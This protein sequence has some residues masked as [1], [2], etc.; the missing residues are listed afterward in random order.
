MKPRHFLLSLLALFACITTKAT[1]GGT[2][3]VSIGDNNTQMTLKILSEASKTV[4]VTSISDNNVTAATIASTYT[5][6]GTEYTVVSIGNFAFKDKDNLIELNLPNTIT[7]I[8]LRAFMGCTALGSLDHTFTIP[9]NVTTIESEAFSGCGYFAGPIPTSVTSIGSGAFTSTG[10]L[11]NQPDGIVYINNMVYTYKGTMPA[12]TS[13]TIAEGTTKI[14]NSAFSGQENL[15]SLTLPTT[16]TSIESYA[17]NGCNNLTTVTV[18][19]TTPPSCPSDAFTNAANCKLYIPDGTLSAYKTASGWKNFNKIIDPTII[20]FEDAGTKSSCLKKW[21]SNRDGQLSFAEAAAVTSIS[22]NAFKSDTNLGAFMELKYFINL[23]TIGDGAFW[24]CTKLKS[25]SFPESL[26]TIGTGAFKLSYPDRDQ[27]SIKKVEF[28]S[29]ES[30]CSL[31]KPGSTSPFYYSSD[32]HLYLNG[33]EVIELVIPTGVTTLCTNMC[34]NCTYLTSVTIPEGVTSIGSYAFQGCTGLTSVTIPEGVT[35]IGGSAFNGCT[36]LT[37]ITI[38]EGVT[39][40]GDNAF[41]GCTGLT[42]VTIS[43]GVTSIGEYAFQGCTNLT[44]V[45]IPEGVTSIGA[46]AFSSCLGLTSVSIPSSVTTIGNNAFNGCNAEI[47]FE[48]NTPTVQNPSA[49]KSKICIVPDDAVDAYKTAWPDCANQIVGESDYALKSYTV[50]AKASSSALVE[51]VGDENTLRVVKLKVSGTINSYDMMVMRTKMINL[52]ELDLSDATIVANS[53]NWG[54]GV[55]EDNVFPG[56][57]PSSMRSVVLP[58]SIAS[59]AGGAFSGKNIQSIVIPASVITIG[60]KAFKNATLRHVEFAPSSH[61]T[62]IGTYA[63]SGTKIESFVSPASLETLGDNAFENCT[64][65]TSVTLSTP[66]TGNAVFKGCT[67]LASVNLLDGVHTI[68]N[69]AFDGCTALSDLHI[70]TGVTSIGGKAFQACGALRSVTIPEGTTSIGN[71]AFSDCTG[72]TSVSFPESLTSIGTYAFQN[73]MGLTS[74]IF[75]ES[76]TSIGTYAFTNCI[77]I[78]SIAIPNVKTISSNT[79]SSCT[80]L[81]DVKLS[82]QTTTIETNAFSGCTSLAEIHLPPYLKSIADGAFASCS[83]LK[84]IYAYMPDII[85]IGSSTFPNM[86]TT[87]LYVPDFLYNSYYYDKNWSQFLH[88]NRC[89]LRPG[90]YESFY[91]NGDIIFEQGEQR[92]TEDTPIAE[93]GSQGGII[94]Q[95]EAQQFD[96][97]DQT[98][99]D[100]NTTSTGA[101]LIGDGETVQ[102]DNLPMNELRVKMTV[103]AKKWYFFCFPFD[104]TI[105]QCEYPG[106]YAWRYYDGA[107]R[108]TNG[109]GGWQPVT[110]ETL[111]ARQGYAFQSETA[112]TLVVKFNRPTFGGNRVKE[113]VAHAAENAANASWNFIGNPYSSYYD[114][115]SEDIT[116]P[117]TIWNGS[118]YVAYRP[119]DDECHLL[120]YQA[121]FIQKPNATDIIS[122]NADR[123]ETYRQSEVTKA[124]RQAKRKEQGINPKRRLV[125][126]QIMDGEEEMDRARIVLNNEAQHAYELECDAAK[127]LSDESKAQLY[128]VEGGLQMAIN[129]RPQQGDIRLGYTAKKAGRLSIS[130]PRMDMPMVL[131]DKKL[132]ITFDLTLGT[133]DFDTQAGT[134]DDRF[135]LSPSKDATAINQLTD[136]TGVCLGMQDGGLAIGGAEGKLINVY[137]TGGAQVASHTGNGLVALKGGIYVVKVD[138]E[139]VKVSVK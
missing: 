70:P 92:I 96:T 59:I 95:G 71:Y 55:S 32:V 36:G 126:L 19:A 43:E 124:N 115:R 47:R 69:Q 16:L 79:F 2:F 94:V 22:S 65:L 89:D 128:S 131:V 38:P 87:T 13:L 35:F 30:M 117:I 34:L 118:S 108:A 26:E 102:E 78:E 132:G 21:D 85:T 17:F 58:N 81:H 1:D 105:E 125:N 106:R 37:S 101:S 114:F 52:R 127:F 91:T 24:D 40:I 23:R 73:C 104:V 133:Y 80:A 50:S 66:T 53:Y 60:N 122:F 49:L 138:G 12:S 107:I 137:T 29:I 75:P 4:E 68:G 139:S 8:G 51:A 15:V 121:F 61:L 28:A 45:T 111:T 83:K 18:N 134:F 129:E 11:Q 41:D 98:I 7:S 99:D 33:Q 84:T 116:S 57:I 113:L 112:G 27:L 88:V 97:V 135:L 76:L 93:I 5:N 20:D 25:I 74:I 6:G 44:S 10:W 54:S 64:V 62:S 120:P 82:P 130:A 67:S 48:S 119:G 110:G 90:D 14:I 103:Q 42:S 3:T 9:S 31:G 39:S 46:S 123:R 56:F 136:K 109:S 63:F 72:L 100:M 86:A 77:G